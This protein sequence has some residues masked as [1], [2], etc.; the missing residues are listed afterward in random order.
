MMR[1]LSQQG[2]ESTVYSRADTPVEDESVEI[3][4]LLGRHR[5]SF[6]VSPDSSFRPVTPKGPSVL[7]TP[8]GPR[9]HSTGTQRC[10]T[11]HLVSPIPS[12]GAQHYAP[13]VESQSPQVEYVEVQRRVERIP[14]SIPRP[15]A[16]DFQ[17][18]RYSSHVGPQL[19]YYP[20]T[21]RPEP[22]TPG[23]RLVDHAH[24]GVY[25]TPSAGPNTQIHA[26]YMPQMDSMPVQAQNIA[27]MLPPSYASVMPR[28]Q[29]GCVEQY[30]LGPV[31][32]RE[33]QVQPYHSPAPR[34]RQFSKEPTKFDGKSDLIDYLNYFMKLAKLNEWEY[35]ICGLQL[36]TSLSDEAREV[37]SN[38]PQTE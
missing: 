27:P 12:V 7:P 25:A 17:Q 37:I 15:V 31:W 20:S 24:Q 35:E 22:M 34:R 26:Q 11:G 8:I 33:P 32:Q 21:P 10:P 16:H 6:A 1:P 28:E 9:L 29:V 19:R 23:S 18:S 38:L 13:E 3:R 2:P 4:G 14:M 5:N 36:A 30:P